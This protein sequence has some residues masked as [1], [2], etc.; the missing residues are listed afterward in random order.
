MRQKSF[1]RVFLYCLWPRLRTTYMVTFAISLLKMRLCHSDTLKPLS[2]M[3]F[4]V[5]H[6]RQGQQSCCGAAAFGLVSPEAKATKT[7]DDVR[8]FFLSLFN[9]ELMVSL[10]WMFPRLNEIWHAVWL[11]SEDESICFWLRSISRFGL[12][13]SPGWNSK[14]DFARLR[15]YSSYSWSTNI[16]TTFDNQVL[17]KA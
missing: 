7:L 8:C 9:I 3:T 17:N 15:C 6:Q 13:V 5:V 14:T 10:N 4:P 1:C 12:I 11:R 16:D 2:I